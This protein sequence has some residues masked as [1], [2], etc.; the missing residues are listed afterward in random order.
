MI[1][2]DLAHIVTH[3]VNQKGDTVSP[4]KLQ[5]LLYYVEAWNLVHLQN[6]LMEEDF[7]AWVHGPVLPSLYHE[8][9]QFKFN[10]LKVVADE[11]DTP[12]DIVNAIIQK[13][14]LTGNQLELIYSV[15]D[16]YGSMNSFQ[17]ELLTHNESPWIEARKGVPPHEPCTNI[18][19]KPKIKLFYSSLIAD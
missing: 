10:D 15:L 12:D 9:K 1:A 14:E 17:L 3:Y 5:K 7:E 8:L 13:N 16:K 11:F 19:P 18:I 2:T 4:K 6:P